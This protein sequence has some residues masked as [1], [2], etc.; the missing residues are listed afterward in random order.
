MKQLKDTCRANAGKSADVL[1]AAIAA[2][3]DAFACGTPFEDDRALV[4]A[5]RLTAGSSS[6]G[7]IVR[8][9]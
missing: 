8:K 1:A 6:E 9:A 3:L 2:D 4:I 5:R 7:S